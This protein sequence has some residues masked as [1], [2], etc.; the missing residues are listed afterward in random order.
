MTLKEV[1]WDPVCFSVQLYFPLHWLTSVFCAVLISWSKDLR[2]SL[3]SRTCTKQSC[4]KLVPLLNCRKN[5]NLLLAAYL[6]QLT[7][8][9]LRFLLLKRGNLIQGHNVTS[10][11]SECCLLKLTLPESCS[12]GRSQ[13]YLAWGSC[14]PGVERSTT[15]AS[16]DDPGEVREGFLCPLCLKD[17]QSFYQLQSHYEEEHLEDRDVK[18]QI[19]SKKWGSFSFHSIKILL[20]FLS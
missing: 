18:G 2:N 11:L 9:F 19:K 10:Q 12:L 7:F 3:F 15:M 8:V 5:R 17:L 20:N 4:Y 16:L 14:F 13:A 6:L 1:P